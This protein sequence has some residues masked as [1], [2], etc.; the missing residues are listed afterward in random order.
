MIKAEKYTIRE[1][2]KLGRLTIADCREITGL[3]Q[4][5]WYRVEVGQAVVY[6][7]ELE[8]IAKKA[9]IKLEQLDISNLKVGDKKYVCF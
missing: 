3:S 7:N 5:Q 6:T 4:A 2:R 1:L 8:E 9:K